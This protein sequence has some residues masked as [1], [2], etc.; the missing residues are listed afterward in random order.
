MPL[1]TI[2]Q[3]RERLGWSDV[4]EQPIAEFSMRWFRVV[5]RDE[6]LPS[7]DFLFDDKVEFLQQLGSGEWHCHPGD[8]DNAIELA[9]KLIRH[10]MCIL[11]EHG[12]QGYSGSGPVAPAE[13]LGTLRLD[14]DHFVRRFF[15]VPAVREAI[16]FSRYAKGK[17]IYVELRR[18][19]ESDALWRLLGKPPPEF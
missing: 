14:A 12:K 19:T 11:E 10:E 18:K 4:R 2:T 5:S 9:R 17:H 8:V 6:S 15:G 3:L 16:D 1:V 7:I 13:V